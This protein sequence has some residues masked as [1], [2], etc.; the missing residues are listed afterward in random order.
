MVRDFSEE[1]KQR[2][3]EMVKEVQPDGIFNKVIDFF[4]DFYNRRIIGVNINQYLNDMDN[5]HRKM[6]DYENISARKIEK[7]FR[8]VETLDKRFKDSFT[9]NN[10]YINIVIERLNQCS[11]N[12]SNAGSSVTSQTSVDTSTPAASPTPNGST[13]VIQKGDT[14]TAIAKRFNTTVDEL[15][16]LNN[17]SNPNLIYAGNTLVL[18]KPNP[19]IGKAAA[20]FINQRKPNGVK[21]PNSIVNNPIPHPTYDQLFSNIPEWVNSNEVLLTQV[22]KHTCTLCSAAMLVRRALILRGDDSWA[23]ITEQSIRPTAWKEG[24]GLYYNFTISGVIVGH[25]DLPG[26]ASNTGKLIGLLREHP[27]GIVL[28]NTN[29]PHAVLL[30]D[31]TDGQFYCSDPIEKG[32]KPLSKAYSVTVENADSYWFVK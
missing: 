25:A 10:R 20:D 30:T 14:L 29:P 13:Y 4:D 8:D 6:I 31:Y 9:E 18:P 3:L 26:G 15:V 24:E 27:E 16:R 17:I 1:Q 22:G 5:Y 19:S 7:I 21:D 12:I 28:Y 32:R 2:L 11:R 23:G